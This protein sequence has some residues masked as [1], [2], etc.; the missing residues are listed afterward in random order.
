MPVSIPLGHLVKATFIHR[1]NRFIIH[2]VLQ[3]ARMEKDIIVAH[4]ADPGRLKEL[5]L[6]GCTVWLRH[7]N[8][9][10][11]KTQWSAILVETSSG[12]LVSLDTMVPN[13]LVQKALEIKSIPALAN[14]KLLQAEYPFGKHRFD[15][16]LQHENAEKDEQM[17]VEVKSVTLAEN[18]VG[19][20]PD[21]ITQRGTQHLLTLADL[22]RIARY[23]T[24][25]LFI[26]QRQDIQSV[27]AAQHIDPKFAQAFEQAHKA[28]VMLF[29]HR[30]SVRLDA[31][32]LDTAIEVNTQYNC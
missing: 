28:G 18:A 20:F 26:A 9:P 1:P 13:K 2:C 16:L 27:Q 11:R 25:V 8:N 24:A 7:S 5:L 17:I 14:Y 21:A 22:A 19:L 6:P 10:V 31:V 12:I 32:T 30:C 15:F 29:A 23:R 3:E 4:L